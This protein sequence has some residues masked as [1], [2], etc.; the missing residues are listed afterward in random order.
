MGS[1][2]SVLQPGQRLSKLVNELVLESANQS[3]GSVWVK[4][5]L[6]IHM[7]SLFGNSKTLA[8]IPPQQ[9]SESFAPDEDLPVLK[10]NPPLAIVQPG[11]QKKFSVEGA[12]TGA[13]WSVN[14]EPG[15]NESVGTIGADGTY[16]AP[17]DI[18]KSLVITL[19][20]EANQQ[21]AGASVDILDKT[22]LF[23]SLRV[24]QSVAY[25]NSLEKLYSAELAILSSAAVLGS[26]KNSL[27]AAVRKPT[28]TTNSEVFEIAP[29][30]TKLSIASYGNEEISKILSF[31][32]SNGKDYLLLSAKTSGRILRLDP[33]TQESEEVFVGLDEPSAMVFDTNTGHLLVAERDKITSVP[34]SSLESGFIS[35]ARTAWAGLSLQST[36]FFPVEN[37]NGIAVD[38]CTGNIY[39]SDSL[40]G[41]IL[42]YVPFTDTLRVLIS[43]RNQPEQLLAVYRSGVACPDAFQLLISE[44]GSDQITLLLPQSG[45]TTTWLEAA[46]S[47]DLTF[48]PSGTPFA[49]SQA[50]VLTQSIGPGPRN[51]HRP[52][53]TYFLWSWYLLKIS[54]AKTQPTRAE[55]QI[56]PE[57][58]SFPIP[59]W[60][61]RCE[62]P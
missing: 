14:G 16:L 58:Q 42:E 25:V 8:N 53:R 3:G 17:S 26:Q 52:M 40:G 41:N 28:T 44:I 11:K 22:A 9:I 38:A 59:I 29:D 7:T 10:I 21:K 60:K 39:L 33:V 18:L 61:P 34:R 2:D 37:S 50:V 56:V 54:I 6:P 35:A 30:S 24:V 23:S 47:T 36:T 27:Q 45:L 57:R 5:D 31:R 1:F 13:T 62:L 32:A 49:P 55:D 43:G 12:T 15:G 51:K 19:M 46:N 48:I 4:T 20:V